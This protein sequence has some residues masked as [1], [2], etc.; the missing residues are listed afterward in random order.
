MVRVEMNYQKESN[1]EGLQ[2][3]QSPQLSEEIPTSNFFQD[4]EDDD[5][6]EKVLD[7]TDFIDHFDK[8]YAWLN[9]LEELRLLKK[10]SEPG[11]IKQDNTFGTNYVD[12]TYETSSDKQIPY[13]LR[14]F[15]EIADDDQQK[16]L[17]LELKLP[18]E[19]EDEEI[20]VPKTPEPSEEQQPEEQDGTEDA[21]SKIIHLDFS[22][23]KKVA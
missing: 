13:T 16:P 17:G 23:I 2:T 3:S 15:S 12:Y 5:V 20:F 21:E 10:I 1:Q 19:Q 9:S 6:P 18:L 8:D 4:Q 11:E 22:K 7:E 14:D